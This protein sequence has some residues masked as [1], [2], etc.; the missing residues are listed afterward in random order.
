MYTEQPSFEIRL[1]GNIDVRI[2]GES[3]HLSSVKQRSILCLL[4]RTANRVV[5]TTELEDELWFGSPPPTAA[6]A[7]RVHIAGLRGALAPAKDRCQI[8]QSGRGYRLDVEPECIDV[9]RFDRASETINGFGLSDLNDTVALWRGEPFD[10]ADSPRLREHALHLKRL[11][12][13]VTER[14]FELQLAA[15]RHHDVV[16]SL[17]DAVRTHPYRERLV[18]HLMLALYR[19]GRQT[20]ALAEF[21]D[22]RRRLLTELGLDPSPQLTTLQLQIL[23]HRV[24]PVPERTEGPDRHSTIGRSDPSNWTVAFPASLARLGGVL[25]GRSGERRLVESELDARAT[26]VAGAT[27]VISG[28]AGLG[29]SRLLE[30]VGAL[31]FAKNMH[32]LHG[33]FSSDGPAFEGIS[34]LLRPI[35]AEVPE[36]LLNGELA[37]AS[38]HLERIVP[39]IAFRRDGQIMARTTETERL[40]LFEAVHSLLKFLRGPG[41]PGGAVLVLDDIQWADDGSLE[42]LRFLSRRGLPKGILLVVAARTGPKSERAAQVL[43]EFARSSTT[44]WIELLAF[45][46]ATVADL[47]RSHHPDRPDSMIDAHT[48]RL[49]ETTAGIPLLVTASLNRGDESTQSADRHAVASVLEDQLRSLSE[50]TAA[51][52]R[53]ASVSAAPFGPEFLESFG[54]GWEEVADALHE[55]L[56]AGVLVRVPASARAFRFRHD[57]WRERLYSRFSDR[58]RIAA[59]AVAGTFANEAGPTW[60]YDLAYHSCLAVPMIDVGL[61][62]SRSTAAAEQALAMQGFE[63]AAQL[64]ERALSLELERPA[65]FR[66]EN[67]RRVTCRARC[68]AGRAWALAGDYGRATERFHEAFAI[69][70]EVNDYQSAAAV[71]LGLTEKGL[72]LL[73]NTRLTQM[74][75]TARTMV[76][77]GER[78]LRLRLDAAYIE[79]LDNDPDWVRVNQAAED[80]VAELRSTNDPVALATA[81]IV[82]G[83]RQN[84]DPDV[85]KLVSVSNEARALTKRSEG[86]AAYLHALDFSVLAQLRVGNLP[87]AKHLLLEYEFVSE[88]YPQPW[89]QCLC[90]SFHATLNMLGGDRARALASIQHAR[91]LGERY[92]TADFEGAYASQL[93][94]DGIFNGSVAPL[95]QAVEAAAAQ[96]STVPAWQCALALAMVHSDRNRNARIQTD[97]AAMVRTAVDE[98]GAGSRKN[99]WLTGLAVAAEFAHHENDSEVG[100][101]V[102]DL[103]RNYTDQLVVVSIGIASLSSV[104]HYAGLALAAA[105]EIPMAADRFR[106]AIDWA[107]RNEAQTCEMDATLRLAEVLERRGDRA[108]RNEIAWLQSQGRQL[109]SATGFTGRLPTQ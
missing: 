66:K 2:A 86:R 107:K 68:I 97:A 82:L 32:V 95:R 16:E 1:L 81:L 96:Y 85:S 58:E 83:R 100:I 33:W 54:H 25:V 102:A 79:S 75:Q 24:P 41:G 80:L 48:E 78:L 6:A 94:V 98:F 30:E 91:A 55:G 9:L 13:E 17:A 101:R 8:V 22:T 108:D 31:A 109:A 77:E 43:A 87:Q 104:D 89:D 65:S 99:F 35:F 27:M 26:D 92:Q 57:L 106:T 52:L 62:V 34:E 45:D 12:I 93:F 61:A 74:I 14:R 56:D 49:L 19:C 84:G 51:V 72:A 88:S 3:I 69:A 64:V 37:S 44:T 15:G 42:L 60:T 40:P 20:E 59:H 39:A 21:E 18:G 36:Q 50:S 5:P 29:K 47:V 70:E 4:A 38:R 63:S 28:A 76:P 11:L 73:T 105:G 53:H 10:G 67:V 46:H 23:D 103:L 90:A 7:L 71:V